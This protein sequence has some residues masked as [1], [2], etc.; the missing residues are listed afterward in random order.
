MTSQSK[1]DCPTTQKSESRESAAERPTSYLTYFRELSLP[2]PVASASGTPPSS[3]SAPV[4][5]VVEIL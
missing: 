4:S 2:W 1:R 3:P 5:S